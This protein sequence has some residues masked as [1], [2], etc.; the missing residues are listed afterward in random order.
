MSDNLALDEI[1]LDQ[2]AAA[3]LADEDRVFAVER[4][5]G[6]VAA[7]TARGGQRLLQRHCVR[8]AEVEPLEA[9]GDE[10]RRAAIRREIEVVGIGDRDRRTGLAGAWIDR[11]QT[12]L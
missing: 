12:A 1:D 11:R 6:V 7:G 4:K 2:A 5:I 8:V 3:E 9:R 10:D